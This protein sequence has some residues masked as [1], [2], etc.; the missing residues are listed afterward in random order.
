M[1]TRVVV[2][3]VALSFSIAGCKKDEPAPPPP[4]PT[5]TPEAA[6]PEAPK[7]PEITAAMLAPF[8]PLPKDA[9]TPD[10]PLT[11]AR[12]ALGRM[13]YFDPRLSKNQALSCNSCHL[14]D[15]YGVDGQP[16]SPGHKGARGARNSPPS[17]TR[18]CTWP[19]SGTAARP[20][21]RPRPRGRC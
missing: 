5:P 12:V 3:L 18:R 10:T 8:A 9:A 15:K 4:A 1:R 17:T 6:K 21:S 20:P 16:T 14:L 11:E 7:A 2:A 19:S 13:L